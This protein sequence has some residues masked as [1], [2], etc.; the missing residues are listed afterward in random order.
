MAGP[1][2]SQRFWLLGVLQ[3]E[4]VAETHVIEQLTECPELV[5]A[6][7]SELRIEQKRRMLRVLSMGA[8]HHPAGREQLEKM[9]CAHI[10]S[11]VCLALEVAEVTGGA[12]DTAL[13]RVLS[14]APVTLETL[15]TIEKAIPYPTTALVKT[16]VVVTRR[17]L[18]MLPAD[19]HDAERAR[20]HLRLGVVLAQAGHADEALRHLEIAVERYRTLVGTDR[21]RYLPDLA[22]SLHKLGI[23]HAEQG[24][25]A[26]ALP[27]L[28]E[29]VGYY[30][31]LDNPGRYRADLA[32]A[33]SNLGLCLAELGRPPS[34]RAG[35]VPPRPRQRLRGA[36]PARG[37]AALLN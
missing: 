17:I 6:E 18:H 14:D 20:W 8:V 13:A 32:A 4:L 26:D 16:A 35:P 27:Y 9:L 33:L 10:E 2:L 11:L 30:R 22:Y 3:P 29:A 15:R 21:P 12:M 24:R 28:E 19:A 5:M 34:A 25:H 36:E 23:L 1:A 7:L 31:E 37:S